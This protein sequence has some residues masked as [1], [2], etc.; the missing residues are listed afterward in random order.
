MPKKALMVKPDHFSVDYVI[1]PHMEGNI[2]KVNKQM[3][4]KQ[5]EAV[6]DAFSGTGLEMHVLDGV[7]GLPDM[8]FCANQSLPYI[9]ED[10]DKE[11]V[12]S[13]M[14]SE[15]RKL[16]VAHIENWYVEQGYEIH[17]L[18][19]KT[20]S[21]FEG[22]GD[23]LWHPGKRLLWGGYGF[24]S[25]LEAYEFIT[26]TWKIPVIALKLSHP[27]FYHLDT[28][29]CILNQ[30][31]VLIY[32]GAF[33]RKGLDLIHELFTNVIESDTYEA[34]KLFSC[35]ATCPN[36]KDV[37]IQRGC[38]DTVKK[39]K[40]AGFNVTEVDTEEFLKSGGSVF[41]MKMLAW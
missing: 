25:S 27:E 29:M 23:A 31:S 41:C 20:I 26:D 18:N 8:V 10:G 7:D 4:L 40:D 32:P 36:G 33:T 38:T 14:H 34:E 22:M 11:V 3:A 2:G 1:N 15:H 17:H 19:Y 37:I 9:N 35:N 24:R 21:D 28:C 13:I 12:M 30:D 5:W 6:R 39:L 16:E